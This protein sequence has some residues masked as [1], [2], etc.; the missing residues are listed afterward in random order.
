MSLIGPLGAGKTEMAKGVAEGLGLSGDRVTSPTFTVAQEWPL[1]G[2]GRLVHADWYRLETEE[3]AMA[4]GLR[5]WLEEGTALLVEWAD[6]LPGVLPADHL[7]VE[8][9]AVEGEANAREI[10]LSA[11]GP[12]A[13]ELLARW[14]AAWR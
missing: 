11:D 2:G 14:R 6:R 8:I 10:A 9:L 4:A 3:E 13:T 7:R 12:R 1:P 5:D